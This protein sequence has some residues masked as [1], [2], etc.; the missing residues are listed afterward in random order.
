MLKWLIHRRLRGFEKTYG[1]DAAY[2][3]EVLDLDLGAFLKFGRAVALSGY[4]KDVPAGAHFAAGLTARD[5]QRPAGLRVPHQRGN[6][7]PRLRDRAGRDRRHLL[8]PQPRQGR[9]PGRMRG[10]GYFVVS[11]T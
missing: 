2:M 5:P 4:R 8:D 6:R 3:H 11:L 9:P 10:A 1:Y 7:D